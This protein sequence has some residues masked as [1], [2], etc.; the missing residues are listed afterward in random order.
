VAG[1]APQDTGAGPAFRPGSGGGDLPA[2][3]ENIRLRM[4][5]AFKKTLAIFS[6]AV[7]SINKSAFMEER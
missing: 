6:T 2:L 7:Q 1:V 5:R 3:R 4:E